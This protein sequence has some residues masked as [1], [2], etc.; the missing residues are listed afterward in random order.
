MNSLSAELNTKSLEN[1][2]RVLSSGLG[3][4]FNDLL[5]RVGNEMADV[6][7]SGAPVRTGK[8]KNNVNFLIG[9]DGTA[10]LT[11]RKSLDK[12]N[13]WYSNIVEHGANIQAK[14]EDYLMFK[15][16]GQW[17]K[18]KSAAAKPRPFMKQVFN[19]YFGDNGKGYESLA[20][21][22]IG[23]INGELEND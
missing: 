5:Q 6:A 7:K 13:V 20:E 14:N 16:N 18:V 2:F 12:S 15:I 23:M 19:D 8:L 10:A 9:K 1:K 17:K 21:E 3:N 4:I 22:L 11:T